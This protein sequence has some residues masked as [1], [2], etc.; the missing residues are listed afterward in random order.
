M[1]LIILSLS[2][3]YD[4]PAKLIEESPQPFDKNYKVRTKK[5]KSDAKMESTYLQDI[6]NHQR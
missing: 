1:L 4:E 3:D 5:I 6:N 2:K